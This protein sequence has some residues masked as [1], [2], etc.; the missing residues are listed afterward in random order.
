[1]HQF[2]LQ[3]GAAV[4]LAS[5]LLFLVEPIAAKQLLPSLGGSAA[6]W[7]TCLVFFQTALLV[8]YLYAHWLAQRSHWRLHLALLLLA[9][10]S[11][12]VWFRQPVHLDSTR[13]V[14]SI[15]LALGVSIG[16]PFLMLGATS[17]LL[18][19]WLAR[20]QTSGIPYRLFALSNLA[21]LLALAAY[22]TLIEPHFTLRVQRLAWCCG[23]GAFAVISGM[24]TWK[25]RS[26]TGSRFKSCATRRN[27]D[28]HC[29]ANSQAA[30]GAA[31]HGRGHAVVRGYQLSHR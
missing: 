31:T 17:P 10:V 27:P 9:A 4:F 5:F 28:R 13:P 24:L 3:F 14:A 12:I 22:P 20:V 21:S 2:R 8:G 23:F 30:L 19:V 15:F 7:L 16:L 29:A 1:M 11:T 25:T 6:V 18:Q 26:A